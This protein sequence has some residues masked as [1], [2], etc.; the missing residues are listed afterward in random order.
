MNHNSYAEIKNLIKEKTKAPRLEKKE[1]I[2]AEY[3]ATQKP[4]CKKHLCRFFLKGKCLFDASQCHFSHGIDDLIFEKPDLESNL[5]KIKE[6]YKPE[7]TKDHTELNE[8]RTKEQK[9]REQP[10]LNL[11][12]T[13]KVLFEF[14]PRMIEMGELEQI[15]SQEE[16]DSVPKLRMVIRNVFQ[17]QLQQR[18]LNFFFNQYDVKFLAKEFVELCY[19]KVGWYAKFKKIINSHCC[20]EVNHP[21]YGP[22]LL[23]LPRIPDF[24]D[25]IE[26]SVVKIFKKHNLI[27]QTPVKS[28]LISD[29]YET[30]LMVNDIFLPSIKFY[31]FRKKAQ[32]DDVLQDF[33]TKES[34]L[35]KLSEA[36]GISEEELKAKKLF[37]H[38]NGENLESRDNLI[39]SYNQRQVVDGKS[40]LCRFFMRGM[41][42]FD[43]KTCKFAHGID[44]LQWK[45]LDIEEYEK[46][47]LD[48]QV[49]QEYSVWQNDWGDV[50][51]ETQ[52]SMNLEFTYS[53][54]F[55]YQK[56]L[57]DRGV[58][59]ELISQERIDT[60]EIERIFI[61]QQMHVELTKQFTNTFDGKSSMNQ[62]YQF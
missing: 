59:K 48:R 29:L 57:V 19:V 7:E 56:K 30:D 46:G 43:A 39:E 15:H 6:T 34:F 40:Q 50:L 53:V 62:S 58:M 13:Y 5:Q 35:K 33:Q 16:I 45:E 23:R 42:I 49:K 47:Y 18:L 14:Q 60:D 37:E 28:S 31:V 51:K 24:E 9:D 17:T 52:P 36:V 44:D 41:C 25:L 38:E 10:S 8:K 26:D 32:M 55:E 22:V 61:R 1:D 11:E 3:F 27:T 12:E 4:E 21:E 2:L 20:Y 54:L